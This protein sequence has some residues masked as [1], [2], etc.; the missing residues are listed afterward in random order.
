MC[1]SGKVIITYLKKNITPFLEHPEPLWEQEGLVLK[2][3]ST[4]RVVAERTHGWSWIRVLALQCR[5]LD[6][7]VCSVWTGAHIR[8]LPEIVDVEAFINH[9]LTLW[10][11]LLSLFSVFSFLKSW[12]L[13][14]TPVCS[15]PTR[16]EVLGA[17]TDVGKEKKPEV[18]EKCVALYFKKKNF[19]TSREGLPFIVSLLCFFL[20]LFSFFS[21]LCSDFFFF[22]FRVVVFL[23]V[24][25]KKIT[26]I[27]YFI[28][29][30]GTCFDRTACF[31]PPGDGQRVWGE[32]VQ[33]FHRDCHG[34]DSGGSH[35][36]DLPRKTNCSLVFNIRSFQIEPLA[37]NKI[38][39]Y[40]VF[41][42]NFFLC[43]HQL[44]IPFK[45]YVL[46]FNIRLMSRG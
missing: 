35:W 10:M 11:F 17:V 16:R 39:K 5:W 38:F 26:L 29:H 44:T 43:G 12:C 36:K 24:F 9:N 42:C 18:W 1:L 20:F 6:G 31:L 41:F 46:M 15:L 19:L 13:H 22:M 7:S 2:A 3:G 34:S 32:F 28:S 37:E 4:L 40:S 21:F 45:V 14:P 8:V 30:L 33:G 23:C 25:F 27:A